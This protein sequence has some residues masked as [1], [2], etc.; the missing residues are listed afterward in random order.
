MNPP[1]TTFGSPS[2]GAEYHHQTMP[3]RMCE[4]LWTLPRSLPPYHRI[5]LM[6]LVLREGR[7][8]HAHR[9]RKGLA[10]LRKGTSVVVRQKAQY[11]LCKSKVVT[12]RSDS[13]I[14]QIVSPYLRSATAQEPESVL[15]AVLVLPAIFLRNI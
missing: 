10:C 8:K 11:S 12:E 2:G 7:G 4:K 13:V 3:Q 15:Q 5:L 9:P 1:A 14:I 6:A